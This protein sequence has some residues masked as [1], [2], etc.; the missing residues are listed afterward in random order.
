MFSRLATIEV[1]KKERR[2]DRNTAPGK[3]VDGITT[4]GGE[5]QPSPDSNHIH[6]LERHW[7]TQRH[8][9][10]TNKSIHSAA[11]PIYL[12]EGI[13]VWYKVQAS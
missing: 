4:G 8:K 2:V 9:T 1:F 7:K 13:G 6:S 12:S 11:T 5:E 3:S 10:T